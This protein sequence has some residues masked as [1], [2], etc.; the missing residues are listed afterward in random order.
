MTQRIASLLCMVVIS[1]E[2]FILNESG[3]FPPSDLFQSKCFS[4]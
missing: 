4:L 2:V 3:L 1:I